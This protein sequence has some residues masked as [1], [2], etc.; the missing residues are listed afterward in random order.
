MH[1]LVVSIKCC[2]STVFNWLSYMAVRLGGGLTSS[3]APCQFYMIGV[4]WWMRH[5]AARGQREMRG[6][7]V[8]WV[9]MWEKTVRENPVLSL[10]WVLNFVCGLMLIKWT[11][12]GVHRID[13][14][15]GQL[16][17]LA[18]AQCSQDHIRKSCSPGRS[19]FLSLAGS[20]A[21]S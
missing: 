4:S 7:V 12:D 16:T 21:R 15:T 17:E 10:S 5:T 9:S 3:S 8:V 14:L 19:T 6:E 2:H 13:D 11:V 1:F 18:G 20:Q